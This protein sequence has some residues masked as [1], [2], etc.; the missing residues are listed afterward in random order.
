MERIVGGAIFL[1][2]MTLFFAIY[3]FLIMGYISG[4]RGGVEYALLGVSI[5][6]ALVAS[7]GVTRVALRSRV[8]RSLVATRGKLAPG[9]LARLQWACCIFIL[10]A[11]GSIVAEAMFSRAANVRV[12]SAE[13]LVVVF[14]SV[15][16]YV[17][18]N[19]WPPRFR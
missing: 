19:G 18:R 7:R 10:L 2:A 3:R 4:E 15:V 16:L 5:A 8:G 13:L 12:Y 1:I 6:L 17:S 11:L 9:R 14:F